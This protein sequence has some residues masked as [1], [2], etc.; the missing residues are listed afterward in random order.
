MTTATDLLKIKGTEVFSTSTS[1]SIHAA[2]QKMAEKDI[3]AILVLDDNKKLSGIF[4]ER[5]FARLCAK[6]GCPPKKLDTPVQDVMTKE[7]FTVTPATTCEECMQLMTDKH[8]RH[9]PVLEDERMVGLI[10]IGDV[11]KA[12]I[13]SQKGFIDQLEGYITGRRW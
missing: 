7:L 2:L 9:L 1:T 6:E 12:I 10:S 3:G 5:D 8:I 11:V 4:S 13:S